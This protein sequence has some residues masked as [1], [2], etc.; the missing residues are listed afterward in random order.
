MEFHGEHLWNMA[1]ELWVTCVFT[2]WM[3][4]GGCY[5]WDGL[6]A[7]R[8]PEESMCKKMPSRILRIP[9]LLFLNMKPLAVCGP[10]VHGELRQILNTHGPINCMVIKERFRRV[11]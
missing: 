8:L 9:R 5:S 3:Q 10:N 2:C 1:T 11:P 6:N 4:P 7:L